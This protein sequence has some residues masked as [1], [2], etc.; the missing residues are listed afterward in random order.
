MLTFWES[1]LFHVIF[2]GFFPTSNESWVQHWRKI[3]K[4]WK[5]GKEISGSYFTSD[6][7]VPF[8]R[9]LRKRCLIVL[10]EDA[11]VRF[12]HPVTQWNLRG[13]RW[14]S[15]EYSTKKEK[16]PPINF[17]VESWNKA[18]NSV[19]PHNLREV[20]FN[21]EFKGA[22]VWDLRPLGFTWFLHHKVSMRMFSLILRRDFLSLG[23]KKIFGKLLRPFVAVIID[24]LRFRCFRHLSIIF[25]SLRACSDSYAHAE[26]TGQELAHAKRARQELMCALSIRVVR[27]R[28]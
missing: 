21:M 3:K 7:T 23:Q 5:T 22:Q 6:G 12:Q 13:G 26:H 18:A 8:I 16:N 20:K 25:N 14:S 9:I 1:Q 11:G 4:P 27:I 15:V 28:N 10:S 2:G 24:F 19:R 17:V